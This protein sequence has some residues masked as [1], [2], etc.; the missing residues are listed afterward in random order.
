MSTLTIVILTCFALLLVLAILTLAAALIWL[1]IRAH[2]YV[3]QFHTDLRQSLGEVEE[4]FSS[5]R[6]ELVNIL[7]EH[8][9]EL[10]ATLASH[11][12]AM[13]AKL[14]SINGDALVRAVARMAI[15]VD[16]AE[17]AALALGSIATGLLSED[18]VK[19]NALEPEAYA[20]A[21]PGEKF[22]T[23]SESARRDAEALRQEDM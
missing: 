22:V 23:Q 15:F 5:F 19:R 16:R 6:A 17:R 18:E 7:S 8:R 21:E 12:A 10:A 2:R 9:R 20:E 4:K 14:K 1:A 3:A 13:D 11:Q